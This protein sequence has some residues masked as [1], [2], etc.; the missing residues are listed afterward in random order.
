MNPIITANDTIHVSPHEIPAG[1]IQRAKARCEFDNPKYLDAKRRGRRTWSI[2]RTLKAWHE[3]GDDMIT[4]PRGIR[5][6]LIGELSAAGIN[7][8]WQSWVCAGDAVTLHFTGDLR[9]YQATA[10]RDM[11]DSMEGVAVMPTGSGKTVTA[12]GLIAEIGRTT[13]I[14][15][16]TK[17][18]LRQWREALARFL[19]VDAGVIGAGKMQI[20]P[21][22]VAMV[23][24]LS[25]MA[26]NNRSAFSEIQRSF[27][28]FIMDEC[29]H[30]PAPNFNAVAS[31]MP[32][33]RRYGLTATPRRQDGLEGLLYAVMGPVV[34]EVKAER[35]VDE[36]HVMPF[37]VEEVQTGWA[38]SVWDPEQYHIVMEEMVC[39]GARNGMIASHA[40]NAV[41]DERV[42]L[43]LT[44]RVEHAL[45]LARMIDAAG[46]NV[47]VAVGDQ[48]S[49]KPAQRAAAIA[50]VSDGR[51]ECL[52]A[53]TLAD[54]GLDIPRLDTLLLATP[55]RG[56]TKIAQRV[57]RIR[58]PMD[59]KPTPLVLD[60]VDQHYAFLNQAKARRKVY[61]SLGVI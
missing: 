4:F 39:D 15:V 14:A 50:D 42:P 10:I 11:Q 19:H 16:H 2:P 13:L 12:C 53:T 49:Q 25:S 61:K 56:E 43:V 3:V 20:E 5:E 26:K 60:F 37:T 32:S 34:H 18:L 28:V 7:A 57:G 48:K 45:L 17:E 31:R 41:L 23:Q 1:I 36:G 44:G 46:I 52:V 6:W 27:G 33:A 22:S 21:V 55:S 24:T 40:V 38:P 59:G 29:H 9:D 30:A 51:A 35:L 47:R 54:E 58:R 8:T